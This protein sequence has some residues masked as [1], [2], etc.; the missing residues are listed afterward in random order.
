MHDKIKQYY[1]EIWGYSGEDEQAM[2]DD[3]GFIINE[4]D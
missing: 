1:K 2:M 3:E 4:R